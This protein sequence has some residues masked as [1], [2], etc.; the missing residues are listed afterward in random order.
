M[1]SLRI[2]IQVTCL[3]ERKTMVYRLVKQNETG[4]LKTHYP[5]HRKEE[6]RTIQTQHSH[7]FE[8]H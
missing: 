4:R 6:Y 1:A 8:S 5:H 3:K 2:E 7:K